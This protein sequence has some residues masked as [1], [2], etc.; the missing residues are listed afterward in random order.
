MPKLKLKKP[1]DNGHQAQPQDARPVELTP[2]NVSGVVV[3]KKDLVEA[4]RIYVPLIAD[5]QA[6]EDGEQ[7]YIML[8]GQA[9]RDEA[10]DMA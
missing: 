4:L 5:I 9:I 7:F 10:A 8:D 6:F 1:D 2:L 3:K